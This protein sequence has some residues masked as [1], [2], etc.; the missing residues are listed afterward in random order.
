MEKQYDNT[1]IETAAVD[2]TKAEDL[3][4]QRN[5]RIASGEDDAQVTEEA[6][7]TVDMV[8]QL[9]QQTV[10]QLGEVDTSPAE[11]PTTD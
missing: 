6:L 1:G 2:H 3:Q 7:A 8:E 11:C 4:R 9:L 10:E 5:L